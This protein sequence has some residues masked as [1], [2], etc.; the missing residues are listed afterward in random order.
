[1]RLVF[2][3]DGAPMI[4]ARNGGNVIT[5]NGENASLYDQIQENYDLLEFRGNIKIPVAQLVSVICDKLHV[6]R[7]M[8]EVTNTW[9]NFTGTHDKFLLFGEIDFQI[10]G[11]QLNGNIFDVT[12]E[13][14][15][16]FDEVFNNNDC[17]YD[18][19]RLEKGCSGD[20]DF[21]VF[22]QDEATQCLCAITESRGE[23]KK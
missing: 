6:R 5:C 9:Y 3:V 18:K 15:E 1:M 10:E 23:S 12:D 14:Y 21:Y 22:W 7:D 19:F 2:K 11:C 17:F 13:M 4:E 16:V 8:V 20:L